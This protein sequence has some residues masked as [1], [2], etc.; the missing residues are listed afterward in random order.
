MTTVDDFKLIYSPDRFGGEH[1]YHQCIV[2]GQDYVST[3]IFK[4]KKMLRELKQY[5]TKIGAIHFD[6]FQDPPHEWSWPDECLDCGGTVREICFKCRPSQTCHYCGGYDHN[7][8][9]NEKFPCIAF[10]TPSHRLVPGYNIRPFSVHYPH[11]STRTV[12]FS[13]G[14]YE[15]RN[16]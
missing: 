10:C 8:L 9:R 2:P 1:S 3:S 6:K 14:T 12:S 15:Q 5:A 13:E 16:F 4:D 7:F 11:N